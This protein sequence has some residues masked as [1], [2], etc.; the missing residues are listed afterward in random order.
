MVDA[1]VAAADVG[2]GDGDRTGHADHVGQ[3]A[4]VWHPDADAGLVT[5]ASCRLS[6]TQ[7]SQPVSLGDHAADPCTFRA[8]ERKTGVRYQGVNNLNFLFKN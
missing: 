6:Q 5:Q 4:A 3:S 8:Q 1:V 2:G 7:L